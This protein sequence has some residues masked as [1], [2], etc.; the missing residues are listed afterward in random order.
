MEGGTEYTVGGGKR[1][2]AL[3]NIQNEKSLYII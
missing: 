2:L 3:Q 1:S